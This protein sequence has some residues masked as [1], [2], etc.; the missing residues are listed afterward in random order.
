VA[1]RL[2]LT[3]AED[4]VQTL[5]LQRQAQED[6]KLLRLNDNINTTNVAGPA[7]AASAGKGSPAGVTSYGAQLQ[8]F[9]PSVRVV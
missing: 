4:K 5:E 6:A 2:A 3:D 1:L 7:T 8:G 9:G